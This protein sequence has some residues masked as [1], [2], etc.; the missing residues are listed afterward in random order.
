MNFT[1]RFCSCVT[2][3]SK[4]CL[5]EKYF[6]LP[7]GLSGSSLVAI[8]SFKRLIHLSVHFK[9]RYK[10]I[11]IVPCENRIIERH[12]YQIQKGS[13]RSSELVNRSILEKI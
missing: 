9:S 2:R 5:E 13:A 12:L 1:Y 8:H 3:L 11:P 10:Y 6:L 7:V 4:L